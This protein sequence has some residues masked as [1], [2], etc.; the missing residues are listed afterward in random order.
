MPSALV[1]RL[2]VES[3]PSEAHRERIRP[4]CDRAVAF[5]EQHHP[6]DPDMMLAAGVLAE[7]FSLLEAAAEATDDP[8]AW[9][10][11]CELLESYGPGLICGPGFERVG[12]SG[13]DPADPAAVEREKRRIAE[14]GIPT[15]LTPQQVEP[16]LRA[17]RAWQEADP[18]NGM[19]VA[20]EA[21]YLYGLHRDRDALILWSQAGRM[22]LMTNHLAER[23][24]KVEGLLHAMG[25]P[26]ADA[27]ASSWAAMIHP[28]SARVRA[29]ARIAYYEGR[30]A[31]MA[32]DAWDAINWWQSTVGLGRHMQESAETILQFLVGVAIEGVGA[33]PVWGW[34][35]DNVTG[36]R[37]GPLLGGRYFHGPQHDFYV[38][39]MGWHADTDM[40]DSLVRAKLRSSLVRWPIDMIFGAL[41]DYHEA[42][43]YL[44]GAGLAA[45]L[46]LVLVF[47]FAACGTWSRRLADDAARLG[48]LWQFVLAV[49]IL[50]PAAVLIA[51]AAVGDVSDPVL[52][53]DP[54]P[55]GPVEG[56]AASI[57]LPAAQAAATAALRAVRAWV[58]ATPYAVMA[59][60]ATSLLAAILLPL[61]AAALARAPGARLRTA[62]RGNLRRVLPVAAALFALLFLFLNFTAV[63]LRSAWAAKWSTPGVTEFSDTVEQLGDA[64]EEPEIPFDAWRAELPPGA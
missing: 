37:N 8:V 23:A 42:N 58:V 25:M 49:L 41:E 54:A 27:I 30:V 14:S 21:R 61:L 13:V 12:G 60:V 11:Y 56:P 24:R 2:D 28:T 7:D 40:R 50:L 62:W 33:R 10:A 4:Y 32:D 63:R 48:G 47:I 31:Q 5:V 43:R 57:A 39:H 15:K 6:A 19:P 20:L 3:D 18:E 46:A 17:L 52:G 1:L 64:W 26:R 35:P 9:A 55:A 53:A 16:N 51:L 22:P 45:A 36:I 44:A 38:Q 34:H 59:L 29:L